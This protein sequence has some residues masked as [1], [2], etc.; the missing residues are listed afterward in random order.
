MPEK[1]QVY[2]HERLRGQWT[3]KSCGPR[4]TTLTPS[5]PYLKSQRI[6]TTGFLQANWE[7]VR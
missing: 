7:R 5:I 2:K 4:W 3:V 1:G 6:P